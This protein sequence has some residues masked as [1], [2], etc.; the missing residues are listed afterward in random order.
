MDTLL[1]HSFLVA[2]AGGVLALD[3]TAV[4]QIMVSR[5][6]VTGPIIGLLFERPE[7]GLMV[8]FLLELLWIGELPVGGSIPAHETAAA[9]IAAG[10]AVGVEKGP[11]GLNRELIAFIVLLVIPVAMVCQWVDKAIRDFNS[12][13]DRL[14]ERYVSRV[15]MYNLMGVIVFLL[16]N[17]LLFFVF[18]F[19]GIIGVSYTAPYLTG[20]V[21]SALLGVFFF[22]P[23]IGIAVVFN[24]ARDKRTVRIYGGQG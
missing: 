5:P 1:W 21:R 17:M 8:G 3:R 10:V 18:T 12:R 19:L 24:T 11:G 16:P 7:A 9:I 4:F 2:L 23:L 14:T 15:G 22:I 6:I 20:V 13:L